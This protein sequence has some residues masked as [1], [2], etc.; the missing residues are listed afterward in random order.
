MYISVMAL[1]VALLAVLLATG[2]V[3]SA[4]VRASFDQIAREADAARNQEHLSDAMRFYREALRLRPAWRDGW[5]S[6]GSLYYDQDRFAEAEAAFRHLVNLTSEQGPGAAFLGLCEYETRDYDQALQHFRAWASAGWPGSPDLLDVAV[7][8]FA[9]LL[10]R[11]GEFVR[12]LYLLAPEAAKAGENPV[13]A[14]AMGLASL[15]MRNLP[16]GFPPEKREMVWLAGEAAIYVAQQPHDFARADQFAER[17][18]SH[19]PREA[20]V[21]YFRGTLFTFEAKSADAEREYREELKISPQHVPA[22]LALAG[23]DLDK[24]ELEEAGSFARKA[25]ELEPKNPEAHHAL[26][27]VL[28]ANGQL[29]TSA[30]ELELAKQLA[31]DSALVRSHLA[32]VYSR[33]G[34][35]QAAKAEASAFIALKGKEGVLAPPEDKLKPSVKEKTQ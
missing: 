35:T 13:L 23:L 6:L 31:P 8:H 3:C 5:W 14:E 32:M 34:R 7:F 29:E 1:G 28:M 16:E 15:R 20:E 10:T 30:K 4:K 21:H 19:Y 12:A 11:Q 27:R 25:V 24:N 2:S 17:L 9:L 33:L 26:G 22:M 18:E